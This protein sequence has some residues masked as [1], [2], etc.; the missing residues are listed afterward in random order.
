[1]TRFV[2]TI[3]DLGARVAIDDFGAGY[4]SF[5]SLKTLDVDLVK[6]DGAFVHGMLHSAQDQA[7]VSALVHV[8]KA[9]SINTVAEWVVRLLPGLAVIV[10]AALA[11]RRCRM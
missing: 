1:M 5:K 3:K 8:A 11:G 4:T 7:F 9:L 6:I 10:F 2:S